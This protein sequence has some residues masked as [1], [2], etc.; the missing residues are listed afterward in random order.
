MSRVYGVI[1]ARVTDVDDPEGLGRVKVEFPWME[2]KNE[3][4]YAPIATLMAGGDRGS[5]YMPEVGDEAL[6]A[7]DQGDVNHPYIVG[8]LWNGAEK[9]PVTDR[10]RRIIRSVNGHEIEIYDP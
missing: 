8:F 4:Y 3:T 2:G 1:S 9:P 6:V 10:H 7:F 5:F